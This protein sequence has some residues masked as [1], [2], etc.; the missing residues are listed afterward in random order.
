MKASNVA[1]WTLALAVGLVA[2]GRQVLDLP[3]LAGGA[4]GAAG[5]GAGGAAGGDPGAGNAAGGGLASGTT[6][7]AG[8]PPVPLTTIVVADHPD[9][10]PAGRECTAS[11]DCSWWQ[12]PDPNAVCCDNLCA[13][14]ARDSLNCG[15]CGHPCGPGKICAGGICVAPVDCTPGSCVDGNVCCA[16]EC[17]RPYNNVNDCGAC[18]HACRFS[19]AGCRQGVC[20]SADQPDAACWM[21]TCGENLVSCP[22]GCKDIGTDPDNCGACGGKCPPDARTCVAG[23]CRGPAPA[24]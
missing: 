9:P 1:A 24:P 22:D 10:G 4:A 6:G 7:A 17:I 5:G 11:S 3:P 20:C 15:A 13:N 18:G 21:S 16:G 14:V 8:A 19:G 12:D 2:C 23:L